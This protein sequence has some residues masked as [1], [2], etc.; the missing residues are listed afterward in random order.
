MVRYK[1][2]HKAETRQRII[3]QAG[4][5][6]KRDGVDRSGI[7][8]LMADAGLTNGAFYAHFSSKDDL[9]AT[10]VADQLQRQR[11]RNWSGELDRA[12]FECFVRDYL[13]PAHRDHPE[14]GCPSAALL[15]D[16]ARSGDAVRQSYT[17]GMLAMSDDVAKLLAEPDPIRARSVALSVFASMAGTLQVARAISDDQ[18][19][20]DLLDQGIAN[21]L[22]L[23]DR[24]APD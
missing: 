6:L 7:V 22:L 3:E 8:S 10:V 14:E 12:S 19:S 20:R 17:V 23:L 21:V 5:R 18:L 15:D 24:S 9:I 16:I 2:D 1:T 13:S 4:R 11:E